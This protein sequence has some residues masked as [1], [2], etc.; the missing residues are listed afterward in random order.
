MANRIFPTI[1]P[2]IRAIFG[3]DDND[4]F[5]VARVDYNGGLLAGP[6]G[7]I[8]TPIGFE[9]I[10]NTVTGEYRG[11]V[12]CTVPTGYLYII[13]NVA[14]IAWANQV[15]QMIFEATI[16][17]SLHTIARWMN[18]PSYETRFA[19]VN[20]VL[21]AGDSIQMTYYASSGGGQMIGHI[22]GYKVRLT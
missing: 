9:V 18:V 21:A 14:G 5:R 20:V 11:L 6:F 15:Y 1:A 22:I 8:E 17:G 7:G 4:D 13:N 16:G 19:M 12:F 3:Q 2:F 10:E